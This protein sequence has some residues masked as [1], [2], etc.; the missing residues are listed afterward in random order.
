MKNLK[1]I[2]SKIPIIQLYKEKISSYNNVLEK[3][4]ESDKPDDDKEKNI[5]ETLIN[6]NNDISVLEKEITPYYNKIQKL[7]EDA[8]KL[9]ISI[10][11][12]YPSL[13]IEDIKS[14]IIPYVADMK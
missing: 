5:Y 1:Q 4:K 12:K 7:S 9:K 3:I 10:Q 11:E 6:L 2:N 8:E 14:Q 13:T